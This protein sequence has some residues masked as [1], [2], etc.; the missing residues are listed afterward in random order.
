MR[1]RARRTARA[2]AR[3][4]LTRGG[5]GLGQVPEQ[6][7]RRRSLPP[8]PAPAQSAPAEGRKCARAAPAAEAPRWPRPQGHVPVKS[9]N[10]KAGSRCQSSPS[11]RP[12]PRRVEQAREGAPSQRRWAVPALS[13]RPCR[14]PASPRENAQRTAIALNATFISEPNKP[15]VR[16]DGQDPQYCPP[17]TRQGAPAGTGERGVRLP[18]PLAPACPPMLACFP[19]HPLPCGISLPAGLRVVLEPPRCVRCRGDGCQGREEERGA[20]QSAADEDG[21]RPVYR[22]QRA[23]LFPSAPTS[24]RA[25]R[26]AGL[27]ASGV[28]GSGWRMPFSW[29]RLVCGT[30]STT[31]PW[32]VNLCLVPD[33]HWSRLCQKLPPFWKS[34]PSG[35]PCFSTLSPSLTLKF[36]MVPTSPCSEH[37]SQDVAAWAPALPQLSLS[38][39]LFIQKGHKSASRSKK[40]H[41]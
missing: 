15:H 3:R 28:F 33:R 14:H 22:I 16:T 19:C 34:L 25:G 17:G 1:S 38:V 21:K 23:A 30:G 4:G 41:R 27:L 2:R 37:G 9:T 6:I 11:P 29:L 10:R 8:A 24:S 18:P 20:A 13:S 5:A 12:S 26:S 32:L 31:Q 35:I 36:G 39:P 7:H 40:D